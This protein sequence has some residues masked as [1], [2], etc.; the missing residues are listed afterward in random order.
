MSRYKYRVGLRRESGLA[1]KRDTPLKPTRSRRHKCRRFRPNKYYEAI[2]EEPELEET[3]D[4]TVK[5]THPVMTRSKPVHSKSVSSTV[6]TENPRDKATS[7]ALPAK[8]KSGSRQSTSD[9]PCIWMTP[10]PELF[11]GDEKSVKEKEQILTV[12][13]ESITSSSIEPDT[14]FSSEDDDEEDCYPLSSTSS[15]LSSPEIFRRESY[16]ESLMFPIKEA[17][18][19]LS[20]NMKNSTL[21][22]VSHAENICMFQPPNLS[23]IT[24]DSPIIDEKKCEINKNGGPEAGTKIHIDSFKSE[25]EQKTP[26]KPTNRKPILYKRVIFKI[27]IIAETFKER[28]TPATKLTNHNNRKP[29]HMSSPAEQM[30]SNAKFFDFA[31]DC[32]R[33]VFFEMMRERACKLKSAPL[34]PLTARKYTEAVK[35]SLVKAKV[36]Y[37]ADDSGRDVF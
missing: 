27:P 20:L 32:E 24:N 5:P 35:S 10:E 8:K 34:F 12:T 9:H 26:P 6:F 17:L 1:N 29:A 28:H 36:F 21:L 11:E 25:K 19:N 16:V 22:D 14:T 23:N 33:D 30:Q 37:F 15:S 2:T 7:H 31:D 13:L 4:P 18:P 3:N